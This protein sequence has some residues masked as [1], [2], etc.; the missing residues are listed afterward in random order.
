MPNA[1]ERIMSVVNGINPAGKTPLVD[2]VKLAAE[3]L[4]LPEAPSSC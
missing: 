1:A 3:V 2:A 4:A